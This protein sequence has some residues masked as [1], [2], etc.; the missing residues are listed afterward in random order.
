MAAGSQRLADHEIGG[1]LCHSPANHAGCRPGGPERARGPLSHRRGPDRGK[2][3]PGARGRLPPDARMDSP[4][5]C[6]RLQRQRDRPALFAPGRRCG[7]C[8]QREELCR[9]DADGF[10]QDALLQPAGAQCRAR[11]SGHARALSF[12]HQSAR[13]GPARGIERTWRRGSTTASASTPTTATRPATR[14][15]RFASAAT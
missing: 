13:A 15:K 6:G 5:A 7:T 4:G 8:A 1:Q 3:H 9:G 14:A 2:A 12:P 11:K 10:R